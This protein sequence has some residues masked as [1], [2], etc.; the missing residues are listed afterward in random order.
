MKRA[1][2]PSFLQDLPIFKALVPEDWILHSFLPQS[3]P[4][5]SEALPV[6]Y[7]LSLGWG[8]PWWESLKRLP[9]NS[10][11]FFPPPFFN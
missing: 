7:K 11:Q 6:L 8:T 3:G 4:R 9:A 5:S 1:L 2:S 10:A